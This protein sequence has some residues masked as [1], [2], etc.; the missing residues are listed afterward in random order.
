MLNSVLFS[1]VLSFTMLNAVPN[2]HQE[3]EVGHTLVDHLQTQSTAPLIHSVRV[4]EPLLYASH[5]YHNVE[6][7]NVKS[8]RLLSMYSVFTE[9]DAV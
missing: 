4:H 9:D 6:V 8:N 3:H 5:R 7:R 1:S 2:F